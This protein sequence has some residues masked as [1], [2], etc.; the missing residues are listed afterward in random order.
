MST[1]TLL[2]QKYLKLETQAERLARYS[3]ATPQDIARAWEKA[4]KA[5]Q[6]WRKA[7]GKKAKAV[8]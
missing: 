6:Q 4:N 2:F 8:C 3:W 1:H 7:T 5:H